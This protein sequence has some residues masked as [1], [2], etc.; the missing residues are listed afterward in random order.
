MGIASAIIYVCDHPG[1]PCV[2]EPRLLPAL[3]RRR[4]NQIQ[5]SVYR[6]RNGQSPISV[7]TAILLANIFTPQYSPRHGKVRYGPDD[8]KRQGEGV[9]LARKLMPVPYVFLISAVEVAAKTQKEKAICCLDS[10]IID[11]RN[12]SSFKPISMGTRPNSFSRCSLA[13]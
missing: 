4:D 7:W 13:S 5:R 6:W 2:R 11:Y 12:M 9:C 8:I 1:K 10:A 3:C